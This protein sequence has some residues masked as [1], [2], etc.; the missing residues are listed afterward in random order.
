MNIGIVDRSLRCILRQSRLL[1]AAHH[2][3]DRERFLLGARR[4]TL[5]QMLAEGTGVRPVIADKVLI[6]DAR[7]LPSPRIG[8]IE[9][10]TLSQGEAQSTKIVAAH[11]IRSNVRAAIRPAVESAR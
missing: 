1:G 10:S 7:P 11:P 8:R 9:E 5:K 3:H 2:A 4:R 6:D